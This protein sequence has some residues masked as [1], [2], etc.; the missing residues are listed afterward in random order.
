MLLTQEEAKKWAEIL[1]G[2]SEGK[3]YKIPYIFNNKG[4]PIEYIN[5]TDFDVNPQCPTI[6]MTY[7]KGFELIS[8]NNVVEVKE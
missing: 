3:R 8:S 6:T 7:T 1:K 5:I 2:F 4:E